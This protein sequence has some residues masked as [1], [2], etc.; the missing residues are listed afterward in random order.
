MTDLPLPYA[1]LLDIRRAPDHECPEGTAMLVMAPSDRLLGRPGY[2]H[3]GAIAGVLEYA[4]YMTLVDALGDPA[5]AA[6][7]VTVTLDYM[8]GGALVETR[9][10]ATILRLGKR[11]AHLEGFAWQD[12][13]DKPIACARM[14]FVLNRDQ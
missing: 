12:D 2:L 14:N 10:C 6:R 13:R 11:I 9:A 7:P 4:C 3:G 8:R 1:A 5:T